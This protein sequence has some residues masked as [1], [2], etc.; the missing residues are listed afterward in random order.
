METITCTAEDVAEAFTEWER[1]YREEPDRFMD[2]PAL[3]E[4]GPEGYGGACA[5]YFLRLLR[6]AGGRSADPRRRAMA[7]GWTPPPPET[8]RFWYHPEH[9]PVH[10]D[11]L[12]GVLRREAGNI[13]GPSQ[14]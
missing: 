9:G 5:P 4:A 2:E 6:E 11:D 3:V 12:A 7:L 14:T 1:R 13:T 8:D 10:E